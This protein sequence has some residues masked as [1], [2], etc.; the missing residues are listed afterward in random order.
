MFC[1]RVQSPTGAMWAVIDTRDRQ[2]KRRFCS[3]IVNAMA[4]GGAKP[5]ALRVAADGH[6]CG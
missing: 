6:N 2:S 1:V 3:S 4:A 5:T